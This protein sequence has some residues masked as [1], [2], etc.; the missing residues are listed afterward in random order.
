MTKIF[1]DAASGTGTW[2]RFP[3]GEE[4]PEVEMQVQLPPEVTRTTQCRCPAKL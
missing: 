3:E 2:E 1:R 4:L